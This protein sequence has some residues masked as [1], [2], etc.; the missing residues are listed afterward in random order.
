MLATS[1]V[2]VFLVFIPPLL[3]VQ[4]PWKLHGGGLA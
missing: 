2:I 3:A 1:G 4:P